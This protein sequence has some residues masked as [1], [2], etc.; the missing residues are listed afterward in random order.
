MA[1]L[2]YYTFFFSESKLDDEIN[3]SKVQTITRFPEIFQ[4]WYQNCINAR[5]YVSFICL[6][7]A[8][9]FEEYFIV[10]YF[11][12]HEI[13]RQ[14]FE[15]KGLLNL[16]IKV[17]AQYKNKVVLIDW[18]FR[19]EACSL[20]SKKLPCRGKKFPCPSNKLF[21]RGFLLSKGLFK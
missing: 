21:A 11:S 16:F 17:K 10:S 12:D 20:S 8:R 15:L 6:E 18:F 5:R 3:L 19:Y 4:T 14:L 1:I 2:T 9:K 7:S 13:F